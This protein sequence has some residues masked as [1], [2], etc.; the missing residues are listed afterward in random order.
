MA[1]KP[2][3]LDWAVAGALPVPAL[4]AIQVVTQ[5]ACAEMI[6]SGT[7]CY[8]DMYYFEEAVAEAT[9]QAG[10]RALP[11]GGGKSVHPR[12]PAAEH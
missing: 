3:D 5:L 11:Q 8:A 6:R 1:A 12:C 7:T 4:T 10:L 9:A 2:R